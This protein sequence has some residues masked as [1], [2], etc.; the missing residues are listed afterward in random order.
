ML[1]YIFQT[2]IKL[3]Y[4]SHFQTIPK[5][6][7]MSFPL[8]IQDHRMVLSRMLRNRTLFISPFYCHVELATPLT[9]RMSLTDTPH[10]LEGFVTPF[11][12]PVH[13]VPAA[14]T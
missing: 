8:L 13:G 14:A 11:M 9:F 4:K 5:L 7:G 3:K 10:I 1:K 2:Q 12:V 6:K